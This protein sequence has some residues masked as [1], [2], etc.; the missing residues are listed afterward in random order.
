MDCADFH[1]DVLALKEIR[2][3]LGNF[4]V[5]RLDADDDKT[6]ILLP[7]GKRM[8]PQ[9][10]FKQKSFTRV[11]ALMFFDEKG[12]NVL[13]TDALVRRQRMTNSVNFVLERAYEKDWTYQ[14]FARSKGIER[15]LK[16]MEEKNK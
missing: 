14:R 8:T 11:P 3:Q 13:E 9:S 16:K 12:N 1:K 4:E 6:G 10:W 2:K 7:S 15:S 5:V